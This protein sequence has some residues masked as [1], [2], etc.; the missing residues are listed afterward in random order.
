M[1]YVP[2]CIQNLTG[3][4][5]GHLSP[6]L[7]FGALQPGA[8]EVQNL[9]KIRVALQQRLF[10][11]T[12]YSESHGEHFGK[13]ELIDGVFNPSFECPERANQIVTNLRDRAFGPSSLPTT[14]ALHHWLV[15]MTP[16]TSNSSRAHGSAGL[17]RATLSTCCRWLPPAKWD[18]L[19]RPGVK[20]SKQPSRKSRIARRMSSSSPWAW[21]L[22]KAIR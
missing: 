18:G 5:I 10:M 19:T 9:F 14:L 4:K 16:N 17:P 20:R 21:I 11:I 22:S 13:S 6:V 15:C 2:Q 1:R 12:I 3:Q 8:V 7:T